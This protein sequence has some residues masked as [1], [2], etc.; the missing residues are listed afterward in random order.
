M[1]P[2]GKNGGDLSEGCHGGLTKRCRHNEILI[3]KAPRRSLSTESSDLMRAIIDAHHMILSAAHP[4]S[5]EEPLGMQ[6]RWEPACALRKVCS[7]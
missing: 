6:I 4:G 1:G 5:S 3:P 7:R 2:T